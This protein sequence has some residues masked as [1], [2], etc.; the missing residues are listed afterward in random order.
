MPPSKCGNKTVACVND[1][2]NRLKAFGDDIDKIFY[3]PIDE[4]DPEKKPI[5]A[6]VASLNIICDIDASKMKTTRDNVKTMV[7]SILRAALAGIRINIGAWCQIFR[8]GPVKTG[9]DAIAA[10]F[11]IT[12]FAIDLANKLFGSGLTGK[13]LDLCNN[14][15]SNEGKN[16]FPHDCNI[17][18]ECFGF[19]A[20]WT[21]PDDC[22]KEMGFIEG[23]LAQIDSNAVLYTLCKNSLEITVN[24]QED[25]S[26]SCS[27]VLT[28]TMK[29]EDFSP[30]PPLPPNAS[31]RPPAGSFE[32]GKKTILDFNQPYKGEAAKARAYK[33]LGDQLIS[34]Y[35]SEILNEFIQIMYKEIST[36]NSNLDKWIANLKKGITSISSSAKKSN[37]LIQQWLVD[38]AQKAFGDTNGPYWNP[39]R[40][41]GGNE[42]A[43]G[44]GPND[45][46]GKIHEALIAKGSPNWNQQDRANKCID[47]IMKTPHEMCTV[48]STEYFTFNDLLNKGIIPPGVRETEFF[49]WWSIQLDATA[50]TNIGRGIIASGEPGL[51]T[52]CTENV[53]ILRTAVKRGEDGIDRLEITYEFRISA[54]WDREKGSVLTKNLGVCNNG[55]IEAFMDD[56]VKVLNATIGPNC[57]S[58]F[59]KII[60]DIPDAGREIKRIGRPPSKAAPC[61]YSWPNEEIRNSQFGQPPPLPNEKEIEHGPQ[62]PDCGFPALP[63]NCQ[64]Y[65]TIFNQEERFQFAEFLFALAIGLDSINVRKTSDEATNLM[66][67]LLNEIRSE[68][69]KIKTDFEKCLSEKKAQ[70]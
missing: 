5:S 37:Y 55:D 40:G 68:F 30:A 9:Y 46:C 41:K 31:G 39:I 62:K 38:Q 42:Q 51:G 18:S 34:K 4:E 15:S 59:E 7:E 19:L 28:A 6:L 64:Q 12:Q 60:I 66:R 13:V 8:G 63:S 17:L 43:G 44:T 48:V 10:C 61:E 14:F 11:N 65:P 56:L 45:C 29:M 16:F 35:E 50:R 1:V 2:I 24:D 25:P 23:P 27:G 49:N 47:E 33:A 58:P 22:G 67:Q 26:S 36:A 69:G 70:G 52:Q 21:L 53:N 3:A 32:T 57:F 20:G 54:M